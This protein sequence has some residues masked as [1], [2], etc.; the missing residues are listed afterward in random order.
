MSTRGAEGTGF[1]C[2]CVLVLGI[3]SV[4]D[5]IIGVEEPFGAVSVR[6]SAAGSTSGMYPCGRLVYDLVVKTV[7]LRAAFER[8]ES[9]TPQSR[10][11]AIFRMDNHQLMMIYGDQR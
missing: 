8:P 6:P 4:L 11:S 7:L 10:M 9:E 1:P 2:F 5:A 3:G